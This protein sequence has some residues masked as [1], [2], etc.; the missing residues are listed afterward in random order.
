MKNLPGRLFR[1]CLLLTAVNASFG[2]GLA[3]EGRI[4]FRPNEWA[5]VSDEELGQARGGFDIGAGLNVSFGIVRTVTI[6]GDLVN[7]TSF[8][9]PDMSK[10]T[11]EQAKIVSAAIAESGIVQNG[12]GN[13]VGAGARSQ[14]AAGTVIQNSLNDQQIQTLT[15]INAGVNSLG[16]LKAINTQTALRDALLGSMRIR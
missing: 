12:S 4:A 13:F 8:D 2:V 3:A 11:A 14:L 7:R 6:N 9:L 16:I 15:I 10:I 1:T 5:A